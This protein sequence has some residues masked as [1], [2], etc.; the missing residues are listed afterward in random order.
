MK[1]IIALTLLCFFGFT[2]VNAQVSIKPGFKAGLNISRF[3][4][5]E[6]SNKKDFYLGGLLAIKFA[7]LYTLQPELVYS[8]QGANVKTYNDFTNPDPIV[9]GSK[10][11]KYSL[12][13][14]SLAVINKFT[15]GPGF[16]VVVGPSIDFKVGDNFKGYTSDDLIG[17]DLAFIAGIG[18]EFRNGITVEARFKQGMADIFG[19]NYNEY[20]DSNNNGNYDEIVLN[21]LFQLGV[22]YSFDLK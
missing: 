21:Q 14:L 15:F 13:Y 18:F 17:L 22:S 2:Q 11:E 10:T 5:T 20:N 7:K 9:Y 12:D 19:N 4:N 3:T 1:R 8:R 16:Q 6:G